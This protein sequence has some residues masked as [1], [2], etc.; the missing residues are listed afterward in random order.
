MASSYRCRMKNLSSAAKTW[1]APLALLAVSA[2]TGCAASTAVKAPETEIRVTKDATKQDLLA[3]YNQMAAGIT[4]LNLSVDLG[5]SAG[6]AYSG[7]IQQYHEVSGFILAKR[8][9][10]VR[11]IGQVLSKISLT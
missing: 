9:A 8:P 10:E 5:P 3:A 11:M 4:T 1:M 7:I 2:V 6:R